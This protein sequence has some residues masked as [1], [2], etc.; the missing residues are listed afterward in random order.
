MKIKILFLLV[1]IL[2]LFIPS[3]KNY[4]SDDK[5]LYADS[6]STIRLSFAGDIMC[7]SPQIDYA[8]IGKDTFDFKPVFRY[9]KNL[10]ERA[11]LAFGN[12]E[13]VTAGK[14]EK[15]T[16]YPLFNS[17]DQLLDALKY[18]GFDILYTVNNHSLDRGIR[19]VVRTIEKI[20]EK[21]MKNIGTSYS[22]SR[23]DSLII[24]DLKGIKL[25][26]LGYTYGLN[27][28]Y[29]PKSK[30]FMVNLID[31]VR[32]DSDIRRL[33]QKGAE[34]VIV[35]FHFGDEYSRNP[36]DFQIETVKKTFHYGADIIIGSHPHV[37]QPM[38][39]QEKV[40]GKIKNGFVAYSLGN[41]ISNQRWRYSDAGVILN[42][43]ISKNI[44]RDSLW[45][46]NVS[47]IPTWVYKGNTG[48]KNEFIIFPSDTNYFKI[49]GFFNEID[50]MKMIQSYYDANEILFRK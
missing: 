14:S 40:N 37:L 33:R 2:L 36:S 26:L 6:I 47:A 34:L 30:S 44:K 21:G 24:I 20:E 42:I 48:N 29:L 43:D 25:G 3:D 11:D 7:H 27:G 50:K 17:P 23:R 28:N 41:F 46:S 32:I 13:T 49:P 38:E 1:S 35:Y 18:A 5:S 31:S 10:I 15:F 4:K 16:G 45:I 19:G 39:F 12:L 8:R 22:E 9:V